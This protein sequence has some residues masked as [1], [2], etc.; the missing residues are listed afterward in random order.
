[1]IGPGDDDDQGD[2]LDDLDELDE[3]AEEIEQAGPV[4]GLDE[5]GIT[6]IPEPPPEAT[7]HDDNRE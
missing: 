2:D 1:M 5:S 6:L 7:E 3:A 4:L